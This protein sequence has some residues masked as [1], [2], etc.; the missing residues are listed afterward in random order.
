MFLFFWMWSQWI[1]LFL[2]DTLTDLYIQT[3]REKDKDG[4]PFSANLF[5]PVVYELSYPYALGQNI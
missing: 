2:I 5:P 1:I 4:S 3:K